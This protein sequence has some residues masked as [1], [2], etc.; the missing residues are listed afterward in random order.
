MKL[1]HTLPLLGILVA[2]SARAVYAPI[3]EPEQGK[4]F[5][6]TVSTAISHDSN[7]FGAPTDEISSMV[8]TVSPA[9]KFNSSVTDQTFL[10]AGYALTLDHFDNRPGD[11]TLD[12]HALNARLAHAFTQAT[13]LDLDDSYNITKNPES[14][15][16]GLPVNS[17][18]SFKSNQFDG[19]FQTNL[20]QKTS[21]TIKVRTLNYDYDNAALATEINRTEYLYGAELSYDLVPETK[22]VG[23]YRH[24]DVDYG[25]AG[26]TKDK[27]SDFLIGGFDYNVARKL[28]ATGRGGYEWRRRD[29]AQ[30]TGAPYAEFSLK[31]DYAAKS[32]LTA[33]YVY[34]FEEATDVATYTDTKVNRFFVNVQHAVTALIVASGS[35]DYEPSQL[36]GRRGISD[37]N[38][39]TTRL[40]AALSYLAGKNWTLAATFDYD[41]VNSDVPSRAMVRNRCG[42]NAAFAF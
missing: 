26:A 29:G 30:D 16:A 3:P 17:D 19:R 34:T 18:Q 4:T 8:Y 12:S 32:Y 20:G 36:Q 15:L 27:H 5:S 40:G 38:E 9:I 33:G 23:E 6:A 24:Q 22:L 42:L 14:L 1:T 35:I 28:T 25:S 39:T 13:N 7:I 31:Y 2:Q 41:H 11:K 21:G 10:S 37:A